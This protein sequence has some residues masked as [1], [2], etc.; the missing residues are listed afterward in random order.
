[1][2]CEKEAQNSS[3]IY[4][5][6]D[7][8]C[9]SRRCS[10]CWI[11]DI[12]IDSTST[13]REL[14]C[15]F[16]GPESCVFCVFALGHLCHAISYISINIIIFPSPPIHQLV[17]KIFQNKVQASGSMFKVESRGYLSIWGRDG[18]YK[19]SINPPSPQYIRNILNPLFRPCILYFCALAQGWEGVVLGF[20]GR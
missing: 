5:K 20:A 10:R 11:S 19:P 17:R 1:M 7:S 8:P 3:K 16:E 9:I 13:S 12:E 15:G 14:R 18:T 4:P 2:R 6:K